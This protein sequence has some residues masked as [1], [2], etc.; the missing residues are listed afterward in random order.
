MRP[1]AGPLYSGAQQSVHD[2]RHLAAFAQFLRNLPRG[3]DARLL[4]QPPVIDGRIAG[5]IF[6]RG[7]HHDVQP[8]HLVAQQP[9]QR[10]PVASVVPLSAQ[11]HHELLVERI[12]LLRQRLLHAMGRVFHQRQTG[13]A[14]LD[15]EPVHF[16]NL[17]GRQNHHAGTPVN[18]ASRRRRPCG[19][20]IAIK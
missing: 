20:P 2:D 14:A 8:S 10:Q 17:F 19:S 4:A 15:R 5:E 12:E 3:H 11:H 1:C 13:D 9:C 16:P 6:R 18:N 7:R